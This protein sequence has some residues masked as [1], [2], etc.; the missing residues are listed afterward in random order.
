MASAIHHKTRQP[1]V[2]GSAGDAMMLQLICFVMIYGCPWAPSVVRQLAAVSRPSVQ[3]L[4]ALGLS[5]DP[6]GK[7][8]ARRVSP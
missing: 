1:H 6:P 4:A 2:E 7:G 5:N 3:I 8:L